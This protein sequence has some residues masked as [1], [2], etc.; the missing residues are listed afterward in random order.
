MG[1]RVNE[2]IIERQSIKNLM[3]D[4]ANT[5]GKVFS[6]WTISMKCAVFALVSP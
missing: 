1:G 3:A 2:G 4:L 6:L 5:R